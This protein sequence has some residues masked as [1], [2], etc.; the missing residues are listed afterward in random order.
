ML[1]AKISLPRSHVRGWVFF[2]PRDCIRA[3]GLSSVSVELE[4]GDHSETRV[5]ASRGTG[6]E[7]ETE[8]GL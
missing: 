3:S 2:S 5:L 1:G 6:V 4:A 7:K 8:A